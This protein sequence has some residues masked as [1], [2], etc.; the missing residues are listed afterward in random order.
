MTGREEIFLLSKVSRLAP[1]HTL[2]SF[3]WVSR[4]HSAE[5]KLPR[6]EANHSQ[7]LCVNGDETSGFVLRMVVSK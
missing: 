5:V 3:Q 4:T 6:S 7:G 2:I 1:G